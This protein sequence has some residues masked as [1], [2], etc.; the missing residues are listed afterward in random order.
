VETAEIESFVHLLES[1]I[2]PNKY[3]PSK[4]RK[5]CVY[6]SVIIDAASEADYDL[7]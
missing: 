6:A 3:N 5:Y 4:R 7:Y 2:T 1:G